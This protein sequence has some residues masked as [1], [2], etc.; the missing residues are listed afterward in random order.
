M[1]RP[2]KKSRG[3]PPSKR[4]VQHP[5]AR[6]GG[7]ARAWWPVAALA[8][9]LVL[10]PAA[11]L[12]LTQRG[13][14]QPTASDEGTSGL[15]NTPDYHSLLVS[16]SDRDSLVL[17]THDGLYGSADGGQSWRQIALGG[18]D[19]RNLADV[20]KGVVWT[21]GHNVLAK[22]SD[23]GLKWRDVSPEGLPHL[24]IHGF[25]VDP[26][27]PTTLWAALAGTGLFRSRDNGATF[28]LVS[29]EVGGGVMALAVGPTGSILAGDMQQGLMISD[30]DG[31]SWRRALEA[32]LMGLALNPSDPNRIVATG[33]GIL[34]STDG[35]ENWD[36]VLSLDDGAGPVAWS[37]TAPGVGYAV[38]FNRTLYRTSDEGMSWQ[39]VGT[40]G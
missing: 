32:R 37:D 15:P 29:R 22:S 13:D 7:P 38:G 12:A 40:Q 34:L 24:D 31:R 39:P 4:P 17:G 8:I 9:A 27:R 2:K 20:G 25:A 5:K 3:T 33:P 28:E 21:A 1:T 18:Q 30:D 23:G 19:A 6:A 36:Q 10:V 35:G 26:R 14:D 16:G 11:Y